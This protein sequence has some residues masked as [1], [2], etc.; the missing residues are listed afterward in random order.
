VVAAEMAYDG[1]REW[2]SDVRI[3][4]RRPNSLPLMADANNIQHALDK[5]WSSGE[6]KTITHCVFSELGDSDFHRAGTESTDAGEVA[7]YAFAKEGP[8]TCMSV[9]FRSQMVYPAYKGILN[10]YIQTQTVIHIE[11]QAKEM[12]LDFPLDRAERSSDLSTVGI[13]DERYLLPTAAYWFGCFRNTFSCF[14]NRIDFRNYRRFEA[15]SSI[16]FDDK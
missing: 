12:P 8:S 15:K 9:L 6:F 5:A 11:L 7:V 1:E 2:Y 14:L 3:D 13:G 16:R 4:G 10:V